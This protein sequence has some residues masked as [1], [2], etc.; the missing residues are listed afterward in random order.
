[1]A[2][3]F[4]SEKDSRIYNGLTVMTILTKLGNAATAENISEEISRITD[5]PM[6]VIEPEVKSILRR[7]I[8]NGFLVKFGKNYL[9]SGQDQV[10]QVDSKR[11]S[12]ENIGKRVTRRKKNVK[13]IQSRTGS[14]DEDSF[15]IHQNVALKLEQTDSADK[16]EDVVI[17][18]PTQAVYA[19]LDDLQ[20]EI[21]S[22]EPTSDEQYHFIDLG[23]IIT[24]NLISSNI[25]R[26][27]EE[28]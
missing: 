2:L 25:D 15:S 27:D 10:V 6:D 21:Q 16:D 1:M 23:G 22:P 17:V 11:K 14:T 4:N 18:R 28:N 12:Y 13:S 3:N 7:G 8:S 19:I 26:T 5:Q 20:R 24:R 9:L